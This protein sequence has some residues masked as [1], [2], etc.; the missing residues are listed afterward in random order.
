VGLKARVQ[1]K[2]KRNEDFLIRRG[3]EAPLYPSGASMRVF[4]GAVLGF[5]LF[6]LLWRGIFVVTNT[7]PHAPASVA[8]Q[9]GAVIFGMLFA[10]LA[11]FIAS[12]IGGRQ[13]FVAAWIVGALIALSAIAVMIRYGIA[14]PQ[15]VALLFMS[16]AT[17]VG[18]WSYVLRKRGREE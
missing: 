6:G 17:V 9:A 12:F 10:L 13:H 4:S 2:I 16:P 5:L 18:G 8:F 7:D 15:V 3:A 11:G 14:W 1:G